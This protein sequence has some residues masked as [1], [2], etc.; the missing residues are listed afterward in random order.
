MDSIAII[1]LHGRFPGADNLDVFWKNLCD[2]VEGLSRFSDEAL[3]ASGVSEDLLRNPAYV[4]AGGVLSDADRFD[5]AFFGYAP[6]EAEEMDPQ[7]RVFLEGA[8]AAL[9]HAGYNPDTYRGAIGVYAGASLNT[10]LPNNLFAGRAFM[11]AMN[12]L[13]VIVGN[14]SEY[15]ATRV[16]YQLNLR[17]PSFA[18]Q[19]ACATSLV[20]TVQACQALL[21]YQCDLALAG[22]VSVRVPQE[23]GYLY[24]TDGIFSPDGHCRAFDARAQGTV[25][26]NGIGIVVLKRLEEALADGDTLYAIIRGAALN[27]DGATKVGYTAPSVDGQA[28]VIAL[29]QA[30]AG[31]APETIGYV[32][33]HGTATA[34]GDPIEIAALNRAFATDKKGFCAIGSVKTNVG[35]LDAAAGVAGLIKTV[36]ALHH[37]QLPP[38]LHF[39]Q[40]NPHIDFASSPFFVNTTLR[41]WPTTGTPRRAGVSSFGIGGT[42]A[43]LVLEEAP[44]PRPSPDDDGPHLLVLSARTETA[45][46]TMTD[47]LAAYLRHHPVGS[48]ADVTFTLQVGRRAFDHRRMVV[49]HDRAEAVAALETRDGSRVRTAI[50]SRKAATPP[51]VFVFPGQGAQYIHMGRGLYETEPVFRQHLDDA[52]ARF[53]PLLGL[54]LRRLLYPE[55]D[56]EPAATAQ[57]EQTWLTQPAL[58]AVEYALARLWQSWGVQPE[59]LIGHSIGELVAA[60]LAG[61]FSLED[62]LA[63]VALRGRRMQEMPTGAMLAISA[64]EAEVR[65]MLVPPLALAVVNSPQQAVASGPAAALDEL[66]QRLSAHGI[67]CRPLHTSHAF[68]SPMME[69]IL[70]ALT[71]ALRGCTLHPPRIPFLSNVTGTWITEAEATDPAYW[72]RQVRQTVRFADGLETLMQDP[73]RVL[74]EVGP[75]RTL[76]ALSG[77]EKARQPVVIASMRHPM[78]A[79]SDRTFLQQAL[80]QLWLAGVTPDWPAVHAKPRRRV[81][82]PTYPFEGQRYWVHPAPAVPSA[83]ATVRKP[84][85]ADWFYVPS[86]ERVPLPVGPPPAPSRW[87]VFVDS[88][89]LGDLVLMRLFAQGHTLIR[90][91]AGASF[92]DLGEEGYRLNPSVA[93]DYDRLFQTLQEQG[94]LPDHLLHLWNV[95][96]DDPTTEEPYTRPFF[97]LLYL[98]QALGNLPGIPPMRLSVVTTGLHAVTGEERGLCPEKALVLGPVRTFPR[99]FPPVRCHTIDLPASETGHFTT[100]QAD[101]LIAEACAAAEDVVVAYRHAHRW[102]EAFAPVRLAPAKGL[103]ERL[104]LRGVYLITG[105]LGGIGLVLADYLARTVQARLILTSRSGLPERAAWAT[106]TA[107]HGAADRISQQIRQVQTLEALGAQVLVLQADAA[108]PEAMQ[109]AFEAARA[110]FGPLHGVIHAAGVRGERMMIANT[111]QQAIRVLDPKVRATRVLET[112]CR[113]LDLDFLVLCSSFV[114]ATGEVGQADYAAA[115]AF[116][117]A[118]AHEQQQFGGMPVVSINWEAWAEVGMGVNTEVPEPLRAQREAL[119]REGLRNDEG[120]EVFARC[121]HA[122]WPQIVVST[123]DFSARRAAHQATTLDTLAPAT[124]SPAAKAP[125]PPSLPSDAP[126]TVLEQAVAETWAQLLGLQRVGRNDNFF[127]LGGNSLLATQLNNRLRQRFAD[128]ELSLRSLFDHPTVAGLAALI[129]E[130]QRPPERPATGPVRAQLEAAPPEARYD[131]LAA[132]L[133]SQIAEA[134]GQT[135][136]HLPPDGSLETLDVER[137]AEHLTWTLKQYLDLTVYVQEI[138]ARHSVDA[139]V[140]FVLEEWT[141]LQGLWPEA[142][143]APVT[144]PSLAPSTARLPEP[145]TREAT[146]KN[147]T[148]VFVLSAPRSGSTLFR[149]MLSGHS[150]LFCPP[151]LTLLGHPDLRQWS[152]DPDILMPREGLVQAFTALMQGERT[153]A[154]ALVDRLVAEACPTLTVFRMLQERLEGRL[155]VDKTPANA[156][157]LETLQRAEA[158]FDQPR[159]LHLVRHPYAVIDSFVRA[160][161]D[162]VR[163]DQGDPFAIAEAYWTTMNQHIETFRQQ[164]DPAR[165]HRVRYEDLVRDPEAVL[166]GVCTF[167][168]L[169]FEEALLHPYQQSEMFGGPGDPN[170]FKHTRIEARLADVWRQVRLP[171][172][173]GE[174]A[175]RLAEQLGYETNFQPVG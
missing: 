65:A 152:Q 88:Q 11:P 155:L 63:F 9:E 51:V 125:M 144:V 35:H 14:G 79:T 154:T 34:L 77:W 26:G 116:L 161:F 128:I 119:L 174:P 163:G 171:R 66:A 83:P 123:V 166:R 105:G 6:R 56:N 91:Q 54:D 126:Q 162:R 37:R 38:S 164:V 142:A 137:I 1:G 141:R 28:Q 42:N 121:L 150:A 102:V 104:R 12:D 140:R 52:A 46:E 61:V 96:G 57:L 50:R 73:R 117:D 108:N 39:E 45:L 98:A 113:P 21:S 76:G 43:H 173:L 169:P 85:R 29:A 80:G 122:G 114:A 68:H 90:V 132:Y 15:L 7:H 22:G 94:Q 49:C 62:A 55:P 110:R 74:L 136:A 4:R 143:T 97:S 89:G 157:R 87:L 19:A 48:L 165:F 146:E 71:Q 18:V 82:L 41:P 147:P 124:A 109:A 130:Q 24:L 92:A 148:M 118:F 81:P 59:A 78:D 120:V 27:N 95:D 10:Y 64:S 33:T 133:K 31:V 93:G 111:P 2:G 100:G 135:V 129:A 8:W 40:P 84:D 5:A 106:W 23:R 69:P 47:N 17:G 3:R 139:L 101:Q 70:P 145:E 13:S 20:A 159:Y 107:T 32:E 58:F 158:C 127:D 151:E 86:W 172:P 60:C 153:A 115:N 156:L 168:A 175:Q 138:R 44:P 75:W 99:E 67:A 103:P 170:I 36:L 149:L 167:L 53:H 30:L 134:T 131:L 25:F 112:L 72:A 16:S 160:R